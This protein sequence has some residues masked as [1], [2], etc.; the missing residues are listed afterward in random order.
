MEKLILLKHV[1]FASCLDH[2]RHGETDTQSP[3]INQNVM[4][5]AAKGWQRVVGEMKINVHCA[6]SGDFDSR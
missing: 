3:Q 4:K 1:A 6:A 2:H 5:Q